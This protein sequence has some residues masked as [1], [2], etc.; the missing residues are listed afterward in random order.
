MSYLVGKLADT[1]AAAET[2]QE[3]FVR[4]YFALKGLKKPDSFFPW[5]LGIADRVVKETYRV[6]SRQQAIG[7]LHQKMSSSKEPDDCLAVPL[8]EA[9]AKL[10]G[11]Y[12]RVILMRYYGG[13]SCKEMSNELGLPIGTITKRLSRAYTILRKSLNQD[14]KN[15]L[16][17]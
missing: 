14:L 2:V 5:L 12:K 15:N 7:L 13:L 4:A 6:S 3:T 1:E 11:G 17:V 16:G 10:P 9:V 8:R